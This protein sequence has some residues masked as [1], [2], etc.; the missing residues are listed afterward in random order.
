MKTFIFDLD[1]TMYRGNAI[2]DSAKVYLDYCIQQNIPFI[3]LTNN[4]MRTRQEIAKHMLD[5]GYEGINPS[6][7]YNSAMAS[8]QYVKDHYKER[9]VYYIG[10]DGLKEA[11]V[12]EGFIFDD[13]HP[14]FVFVGLQKDIDYNGYSKALSYLLNGAKLIGTNKD[15]ILAKPSG[16]ELGNGAIISM[17]EYASKQ[18]S[19]DIAKPS[20]VI[21]EYCCKYFDL[22]YEDIVLIG[23]NL[24]TDIKLGFNLSIKTVFVQTGIHTKSDIDSLKIYPDVIVDELSDLIGVDL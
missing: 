24:E 8:V 17:F 15:R 23:D 21:L 19:P 9:K 5:M 18:I 12:E 3:F 7:F 22:N 4:A 10:C 13:Q 2:I 20:C 6:M 16:F 11:L 14:D 1:G